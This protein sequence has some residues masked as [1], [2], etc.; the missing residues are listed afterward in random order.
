MIL[1]HGPLLGSSPS[2][3]PPPSPSCPS[4]PACLGAQPPPL[5]AGWGELEA[6]AG[7]AVLLFIAFVPLALLCWI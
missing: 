5:G 3:A 7:G 4:P 6:R 2:Q 1:C